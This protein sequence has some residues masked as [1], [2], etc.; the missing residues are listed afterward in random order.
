MYV[1]MYMLFMCMCVCRAFKSGYVD[2]ATHEEA[3]ETLQQEVTIRGSILNLDMAD[4]YK[5][6]KKLLR[7]SCVVRCLRLI[8]LN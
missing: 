6:E 2:F 4:Y 5:A 1:C 7:K 3:A 8:H